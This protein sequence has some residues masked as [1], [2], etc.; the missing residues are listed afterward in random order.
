MTYSI[1]IGTM[2]GGQ[3]QQGTKNSSQVAV[4][5][6]NST[7]LTKA[8]DDLAA[9][10]LRAPEKPTRIAEIEADIATIRAQLAK[11]EPSK[12]ILQEAGSSLRKLVEGVAAETLTP[13]VM[14]AAQTLFRMLGLA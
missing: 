1:S 4:D 6:F 5:S 8:I 13:G 7:D 11:P 2:Q 9:E 14:S 10:F 12:S 3:V